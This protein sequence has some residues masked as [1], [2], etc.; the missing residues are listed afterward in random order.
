[1][2]GGVTTTWSGYD[3]LNRPQGKSYTLNN[4]PQGTPP[5]TYGYDVGWKGALS[6]VGASVGSSVYSTSY[7]FGRVTSSSQ[8]TV[9]LPA[10][11]FSYIYSYAD[12]LTQIQYPS[13][14]TLNYTP[15]SAG[16]II[17]V[18]SGTTG[19]IYAGSIGYTAAGGI[20]T[21]SGTEA[22][23]FDGSKELLFRVRRNI[24]SWLAA[25]LDLDPFAL[26]PL[27]SER[28]P[29]LCARVLEAVASNDW[30]SIMHGLYLVGQFVLPT[31]SDQRSLQALRAVQRL[32]A[33]RIFIRLANTLQNRV[34]DRHRIRITAYVNSHRAKKS[35]YFACREPLT[36]FFQEIAANVRQSCFS[37]NATWIIFN[38]WRDCANE[39]VQ[40]L[41]AI[42]DP[43]Q[44]LRKIGSFLLNSRKLFLGN[45]QRL[46]MGVFI[47]DWHTRSL[48]DA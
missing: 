37:R 34:E 4:S 13:T 42:F 12:E 45:Y 35:T 5:V 26:W 22:L 24:F 48:H 8:T 36:I 6:S 47:N 10:Y 19:P 40:L 1:M 11:T 18:Q 44:A 29:V 17:S 20:S 9:A 38:E 16:M 14:R 21:L 46:F 3:G 15:D 25:T 30:S 23:F 32:A 31:S 39:S 41:D 2:R 27:T 43:C 28:F 7:G 33:C